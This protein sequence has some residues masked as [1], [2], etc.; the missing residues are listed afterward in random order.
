MNFTGNGTAQT[1]PGNS[2]SCG[3][4]LI[5]GNNLSCVSNLHLQSITGVTLTN[6]N[7]TTGG[8]MGINGNA[9]SG[10]SLV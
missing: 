4:N 1:V 2:A 8:Q 6:L 3:G 7:V 10:F 9:V 5:G